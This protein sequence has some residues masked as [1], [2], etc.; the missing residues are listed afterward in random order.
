MNKSEFGKRV[1][2]LRK[3]KGWTQEELASLAQVSLTTI[4]DIEW[5]ARD[6]SISVVEKISGV[7]GMK[8]EEI[9]YGEGA[10]FTKDL[11]SRFKQIA[12]LPKE[13]QKMICTMIDSI[14][15]KNQMQNIQKAK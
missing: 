5:G 13:E 4:K 3:T 2:K 6:P 8:M 10:E 9:I 12:F 14:V 15:L 7:F 11:E 1:R